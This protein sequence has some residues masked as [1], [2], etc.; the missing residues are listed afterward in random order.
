MI[1]YICLPDTR[2]KRIEITSTTSETKEMK[3]KI[4]CSTG[5]SIGR[6]NNCDYRIMADIAPMLDCDGFELMML[7]AY[8]D[9][10]DDIPSFF[11]NTGM[12]FPVIHADKQIGD[13]I[14]KNEDGDANEAIRRFR[15]NCKL[16]ADMN[17]ERIVLHLWGGVASDKT[18]Q[19]NIDFAEILLPIAKEYGLRLT[20]ENIPCVIAD[21]LS[22]WKVLADRYDELDFIFDTRF[23]GFHTQLEQVISDGWL[24]ARV[25][26]MHV[27]DFTGPP[28]DF[29]TLRPILHPG[30]GIVDLDTFFKNA[31]P[32]YDGT[33]TLESPVI[34]EDGTLDI[35]K[36][37]NSLKYIRKQVN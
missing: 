6:E 26:H 37:N 23:G 16:G 4:I 27:S 31:A 25:K 24:G 1:N 15:L 9:C 22:H 10:L 32:V 8:Y 33:I 30:E 19:L 29:T 17:C 7:R 34:R 36:L 21:P 18:I 20:V 3:N 13:L 14:S 11:R 5:T 35:E 2:A 12:K 28:K